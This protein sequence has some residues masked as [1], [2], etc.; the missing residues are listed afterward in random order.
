MPGMRNTVKELEMSERHLAWGAACYRHGILTSS[1][2]N[3][4]EARVQHCQLSRKDTMIC[5]TSVDLLWVGHMC[6]YGI[7]VPVLD[8]F[9]AWVILCQKRLRNTKNAPIRGLLVHLGVLLWHEGY[10]D[11]P[12]VVS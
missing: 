8:F 1:K 7:Q 2:W 12:I 4:I 11:P 9:R 5:D 6:L 10:K 3:S